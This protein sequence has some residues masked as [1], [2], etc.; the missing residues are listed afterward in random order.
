LMGSSTPCVFTTLKIVWF[1]STLSTQKH[2]TILACTLS[3]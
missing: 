3:F 1:T 2:T